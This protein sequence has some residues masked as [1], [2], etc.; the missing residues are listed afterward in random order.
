MTTIAP[1]RSVA[2]VAHDLIYAARISAVQSHAF[3]FLRNKRR[4]A[5][6]GVHPS[7]KIV[8]RGDFRYGTGVGIDE[9][10][11]IIIPVGAALE[12][13]ANSRIG[14]L[15]ELGPST[16]IRLG[17]QVSIQD[18]SILVGNVTI[19]C[20]SFLSL[21]VLMTS[22]THIYDRWPELLIRDQDTRAALD[23][24]S[25]GR[26]DRPIVIEEDCWIGMNAVIMPG[27]TIGRGAVVGSNAVVSRDVPPYAVVAGVP[28]RIIKQRLDF[29]PPVQI[30]W[31]EIG[32]IPYFYRGFALSLQERARNKP[33]GGHLST[34][35]FAVWLTTPTGANIQLEARSAG[36]ESMLLA[37]DGSGSSIGTD[38]STARFR[39]LADCDP[40]RVRVSGAP[41]IIRSAAAA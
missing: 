35:D 14:R 31:D 9:G 38:W 24:A 12:I 15:V 33:L 40:I 13:G 3:Q 28:A 32:H 26:S 2:E 29:H 18:R 39:R 25:D 4:F 21:N 19:G 20:Y 11:T 37:D 36:N 16:L 8:N 6:L 34:G 5:G 1:W 10:S 17:D 30:K 23:P 27:V 41:V 22:G 7:A